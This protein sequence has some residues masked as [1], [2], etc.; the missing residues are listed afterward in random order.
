MWLLLKNIVIYLE[1]LISYDENSC[2]DSTIFLRGGCI[3]VLSHW[4]DLGSDLLNPLNC[5][6]NLRQCL[7]HSAENDDTG[8][9]QRKE[10]EETDGDGLLGTSTQVWAIR[11]IFWLDFWSHK[12]VFDFKKTW[13]Q[14]VPLILI[15]RFSSNLWLHD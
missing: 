8:E 5:S 6:P 4:D 7:Q 13:N 3:A 9:R 1:D 12:L 14:E 2:C 10:K 11:L 15:N